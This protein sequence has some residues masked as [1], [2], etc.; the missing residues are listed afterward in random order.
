MA[1]VATDEEDIEHYF[2]FVE[3]IDELPNVA[4]TGEVP[5]GWSSVLQRRQA[6]HLRL[7]THA[8]WLDCVREEYFL[9]LE[10]LNEV[11]E[12][13]NRVHAAQRRERLQSL[14][15]TQFVVA[16]VL[17]SDAMVDEN[18]PLGEF[19]GAAWHKVSL[20]KS[21][22]IPASVDSD[23]DLALESVTAQVRYVRYEAKCTDE[24]RLA[25]LNVFSLNFIPDVDFDEGNHSPG[26]AITP[27]KS[28]PNQK[29][30]REWNLGTY[31]ALMRLRLKKYPG[32]EIKGS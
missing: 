21:N 26:N 27:P 31:D 30:E 11:C 16:L 9:G 12:P 13:G 6:D 20:R 5:L 10:W 4:L 17:L 8:L 28:P 3:S 7:P 18:Y 1:T 32:F 15:P 2:A 29:S 19:F 22:G 24:E 14:D 25:L 23:F